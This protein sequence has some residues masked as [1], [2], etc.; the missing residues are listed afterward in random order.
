MLFSLSEINNVIGVVNLRNTKCEDLSFSG[1]SIDSR[2]ITNKD[3]FIAIKGNFFD[4]HDFIS[5]V[6]DKGVKAIVI[7][8]NKKFLVPDDYPYW[9]VSDT[10][11]ALQKIAL[12]KRKKLNIPVVAITGSVG[13]TTTKDMTGELMKRYGKIKVSDQNNNNEIGVALTI[14]GADSNSKLLV[15]EMGMRGEGQIENL[16]KYSE[17]DIAIITNIG[18]SHIG[19]LG[20]KDNIAKA[21]CEIVKSLNPKGLVIV[22]E[23]DLILE[24]YLVNEWKGRVLRI[25]LIN[26]Q[27]EKKFIQQKKETLTGVYQ[28]KENRIKIDNKQFKISYKGLHNAYNFLFAYAVSQ[29]FGIKFG[30]NNFFE[31][32]RYLGRNNLIRNNK[33][34]IMDETYN[35]S[36]ESVKACISVLIEYPGKHFLVL[37]SMKE[38]GNLSAQYHLEILNFVNKVDIELCLFVC[39]KNEENLLKKNINCKRIIFQNDKFNVPRILN[40]RTNKNDYVLI[41][42][43]RFW[44]LEEII[45]LID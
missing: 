9:A 39:D 30:K 20:S 32:K 22:P 7:D 17:P 36:P 42:G 43:S 27:D 23:G 25:N 35:A 45:P 15:I 24:K 37:G 5:E 26:I 18:T 1:I 38:L 21:K 10:L 14:L 2:N 40:G 4:G 12:L 6:I 16:S 28:D 3:L 31:F 33:V 34:M 41:K 44:K 13:K 11:E 29:E 8:K 19:I